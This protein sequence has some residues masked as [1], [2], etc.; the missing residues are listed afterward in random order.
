MT[1]AING[2]DAVVSNNQ[3]AANIRDNTRVDVV[4]TYPVPVTGAGEHAEPYLVI[5]LIMTTAALLFVCR[6][7]EEKAYECSSL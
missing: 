1:A 3:V 5:L 2:V 4:N 7:K 6:R